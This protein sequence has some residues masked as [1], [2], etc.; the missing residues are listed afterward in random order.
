MKPKLEAMHP[1][2]RDRLETVAKQV[3][4]RQWMGRLKQFGWLA[5]GITWVFTGLLA[6]FSPDGRAGTILFVAYASSIVLSAGFILYRWSRR[7]ITLEQVALYIDEHHPELEN[8]I[9]S[10]LNLATD[11]PAG[12]SKWLIERF[13]E[14]TVPIV[15]GTSFSDVI[16]QRVSYG[17]IVS[18]VSI[19]MSSGIVLYLF[20]SLWLPSL[21]FILPTK[22]AEVVALPFT[23]EPGDVRVRRGDNQMIWI[24]TKDVDRSLRMRWRMPGGAW[25]D[26]EV[27]RTDSENVMYYQFLNVQ[28]DIDYQVLYGRRRSPS[29]R[30]TVWTPPEVESID[31]IYHYPEYLQREAREVPNSGNITAIEGT[32]VDVEVWVNK[33]IKQA[34]LILESG[35]RLTLQQRA[36][37]LWFVPLTIERNDSY[38]IELFDLDEQESEYNPEYKIT[39]ARDK[40]PEIHIDFPRGD[41]EVTLLEEVPFDFNVSDD[42]GFREFG[43]QFEVAGREPVRI[44]LNEGSDLIMEAEGHHQMMLEDMNL[45]VGDFI[46]WTIW[47]TDTKPD[48]SEFELMGDPY[49]LEIRPFKRQYREAVSGAGGGGGGMQDDDVEQAQ[50]DVL[51][52]TWN[53]RRESKYMDDEEFTEKREVIVETQGELLDK[54]AEAGGMMQSPNRDMLKLRESMRGSVEALTRAELPQ[55][56]ADLS[57]ATVHQQ[58]SLRLIARLKPR[59]AEVQQQQ[60][61]GGGGGGGQE[62]RPDISELEMARNRN[63]YEQESVTREQQEAADEVLKKIK[64]LARRQQGVNEELAKL[65]SEMQSAETEEERQRLQRKLEHLREEMR[66]NLESLDQARQQLSSDRLSNEQVRTAQE[67]LERARRQMNRSLE[68]LERDRLQQARTSGSRAMDALGDIQRH[69]QQFGRGAAA[70]RMRELQETMDGLRDRQHEIAAEAIQAREYH[71][72]PSMEDQ[73]ALETTTEDLQEKKEQL[74]QDFVKMMDEASEIAERSRQTQQLMS[75]KLGDWLR[76]TSRE[77]LLEDIEESQPFIEYGIWDTAVREERSIARKFDAAAERLRQ[78]AE[79]LVDDDLEAM[80]QA[81]ERMDNLLDREEVTGASGEESEN[82]GR[83]EARA[84]EGEGE[85]GQVPGEGDETRGRVARAEE[86]GESGMAQSDSGQEGEQSSGESGQP[87]DGSQNQDQ[88]GSATGGAFDSRRAMRNFA[89]SGYRDWIDDLRDAETLLP[90]G[91]D[92]RT[93]VTRIRERVERI[94]REWR[95]RALAPQYDLFLEMVARPLQDVAEML[96]REIE[97]TLNEKEFLLTDEGDIPERYK[98]RVSKYFKSLS[99]AEGVNR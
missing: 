67:A 47:A 75:N 38:R 69:L 66:E 8:R 51:I 28:T 49:F 24:R 60:G 73:K 52:A 42:Y 97:K 2:L 37:K 57:E 9:A 31:L 11:R 98:D 36:D 64:E 80:Q 45:E 26:S 39:M 62:N 63:F 96:Q 41:N 40:A 4:R 84:E 82:G 78:V 68:Q 18:A 7:P 88:R 74:A 15:L 65:I 76:E 56:K 35:E 17:L 59:Q 53:L 81:L 20:G 95:A 99:A 25:Q 83:G 30:V 61:G 12:A 92:L 43:L 46:T 50:K 14:E 29:F 87:Q 21:Q 32:V 90:E 33:I 44:T 22:V 91:T 54:L 34:D 10:A 79:N 6:V 72:S 94:R 58:M 16:R 55:P 71:N 85:E 1:E 27:N 77:G 48:R 5:F 23:V 86:G 70:E 13:V 93:E 3:R 19:L 89:D